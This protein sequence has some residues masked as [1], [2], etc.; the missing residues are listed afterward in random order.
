MN[1]PEGR[2]CL[3]HGSSCKNYPAQINGFAAGFS[4]TS[5]SGL[6]S[7]SDAVVGLMAKDKPVVSIVVVVVV[8]VVVVLHY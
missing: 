2:N 7:G 4:C 6:S 1:T 3:A 8:V 5:V